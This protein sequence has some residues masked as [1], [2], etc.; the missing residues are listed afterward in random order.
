MKGNLLVCHRAKDLYYICVKHQVATLRSGESTFSTVGTSCGLGGSHL[1]G[2]DGMGGRAA[3]CCFNFSEKSIKHHIVENWQVKSTMF[4]MT[5]CVFSGEAEKTPKAKSN[6][7]N[8]TD[9]IYCLTLHAV[10]SLQTL[11]KHIILRNCKT[12]QYC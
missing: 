3:R 11:L 5:F 7:E 8:K 9:E 12:S 10:F 1:G 4:Q 6:S 2:W